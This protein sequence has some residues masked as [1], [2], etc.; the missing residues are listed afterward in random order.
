MPAVALL[1]AV[2]TIGF[3]QLVQ[4][5][6]GASGIIGLL[7]LATGIKAK[8]TEIPLARLRAASRTT[9]FA[10][11]LAGR[12]R[13]HLRE[14]WASV[15]AGAPEADVVLTARR[16]FVLALGFLLAAGRMRL[17]DLTGALWVPVDWLVSVPARTNAAITFLLGCFALCIERH[18]G[19]YTL[20]T[21]G[22]G[23]L[24]A[25]GFVLRQFFGWL[26]RLRGIELSTARN[27]SS[28]E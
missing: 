22:V 21:E 28:D 8:G 9:S 16:Q 3:E 17:H 15:L 10:A 12:R 20:L 7:L 23:W 11:G 26:R 19:L 5:K 14:E 4:W 1:S 18:D 2:F 13:A 24:V 6:Y 25:S 27:D